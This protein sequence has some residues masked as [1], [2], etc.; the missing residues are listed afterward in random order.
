M[1]IPD[2]TAVLN[3]RPGFCLRLRPLFYADQS[4]VPVPGYQ[5]FFC[6][7]FHFCLS[8][9]GLSLL[10]LRIVL[11]SAAAG[12]LSLLL[13]SKEREPALQRR[14]Y[15]F[16]YSP[17]AACILSV[18]SCRCHPVNGLLS[19]PSCRHSPTPKVA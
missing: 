15:K 1:K 10:T 2:F 7:S 4:T 3:F 9:Q 17:A 14:P 16:E 6:Q 19:V 18:P 8:E 12:S 5:L 13:Q 11:V